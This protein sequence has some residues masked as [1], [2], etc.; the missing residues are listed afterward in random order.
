MGRKDFFLLFFLLLCMRVFE[1]GG[2]IGMGIRGLGD[3]EGA[4][5]GGWRMEEEDDD[6]DDDDVVCCCC[7][8]RHLFTLYSLHSL[9]PLLQ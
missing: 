4:M 1:E 5:D 8:R 6:D 9:N 7:R 2:W 3:R